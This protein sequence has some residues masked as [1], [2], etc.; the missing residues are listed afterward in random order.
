MQINSLSYIPFAHA[1]LAGSL[2]K[3]KDDF[4]K[5]KKNK[6]VLIEKPN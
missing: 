4:K 5:K 6:L 2:K 3:M 1:H